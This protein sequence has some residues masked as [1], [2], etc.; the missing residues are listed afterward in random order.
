VENTLFLRKPIENLY[1]MRVSPFPNLFSAVILA[2]TLRRATFGRTERMLSL[3]CEN[4]GEKVELDGV[5]VTTLPSPLCIAKVNE[6]EMKM[7]CKL[8]YRT[9]YLIQAAKAICQGKTRPLES[10]NGMPFKNA[11]DILTRIK[12]IGIYSC[13]VICTHPAFPVDSW[14]AKY[15]I[16]LFNIEVGQ[17]YGPPDLISKVKKFAEENFGIWQ[18]YAY[19]YLVNSDEYSTK[20][21]GI[22]G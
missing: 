1:G 22:G 10:L 5:Q 2:I 16:S 13:E 7:R 17:T 9:P 4:Y 20:N 18:R 19:E 15:F 6:K 3:L 21:Q 8:G 14:S 11:V 12:G